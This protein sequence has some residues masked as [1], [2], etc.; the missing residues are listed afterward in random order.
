MKGTGDN[1]LSLHRLFKELQRTTC[2]D[3]TVTPAEFQ[4]R[5]LTAAPHRQPHG[6]TASSLFLRTPNGLACPGV[7]RPEPQLLTSSCF[8]L[9]EVLRI[10]SPKR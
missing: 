1:L 9:L 8:S 2:F 4:P 3:L 7:S 5:P 10:Q 6:Q